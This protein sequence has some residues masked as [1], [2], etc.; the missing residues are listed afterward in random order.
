MPMTPDFATATLPLA[1][2]V[3][4]LFDR[5]TAGTSGQANASVDLNQQVDYSCKPWRADNSKFTVPSSVTF[6]DLS[7]MMKGGISLPA[8]Y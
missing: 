5:V 2:Y 6:T 3:V 1:L 8:G 7:A 4:N